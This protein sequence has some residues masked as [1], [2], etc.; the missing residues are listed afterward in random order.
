MNA[1]AHPADGFGRR[2]TG[3][4][5]KVL[6]QTELRQWEHRCI[7]EEPPPCMAA[8]PLHVDA[9][10]MAGHLQAGQWAE[11]L[12]VLHKTM[13]LPG[14]LGRICD[15]PCRLAC[16]RKDVG[17]AIQIVALERACVQHIEDRR[18]T[19]PLTAKGL[20]V[21]VI[22]GGLS[23]LTA[24]WDLARKGYGVTVF[25]DEDTVGRGLFNQYRQRLSREVLDREIALLTSLKVRFE[26]K[27][28]FAS[29]A[30]SRKCREAHDAV[31]VGLDAAEPAPWGIDS[32][33]GPDPAG[34]FGTTVQD[35]L[36]AGG[37][38]AS[39]IWQAAQGRW[40][41]TTTDRW[42]Q[43]VSLT[44]G[45]EK[46]GPQATRLFTNF[47]GIPPK[48]AV[49]MADPSAGYSQTE[50][51]AEAERCLQCQCL[52]CV[53]VCAYLEQF[54]SYPRR[55]A[56]E[57]YNNESLVLGERKANRLINSCSLCGLCE[58]VC[59]NDFAMQDLCLAARQSMVA[60][61]KMPPSAHAFALQDMAFSQSERFRLAR[62]EPGHSS[63]RRLFFPGCQLCA[64][65]PRQVAQIYRHLREALTDGVA[66]MLGCCGAPAHWAGR[67][68]SLAAE[69]ARW[70][71][72]WT[73]LGRPQPIMACATCLRIFK[74]HV[75]ETDA[76]SLWE[77][78]DAGDLPEGFFSHLEEPLAVHDPC[79]T[80]GEE[81]VQDA[82]RR[83]LSRM[84][85]PHEELHLGRGY[86]ECC[87]FGG[88]M[89]NANPALAR[90][91]AENRGRRSARDYLAYCA[92][93]RDSLAA[94][95]KRTLHLLDLFFPDPDQPDP[96]ARPRPG[97][98]RRRENRLRLKADLSR[99]LWN[100][101]PAADIAVPPALQMDPEVEALL[102]SRRILE[103]DIQKVIRHI[104][105]GGQAFRHPDTGHWL[106]CFR[107]YQAT[108]WVEFSALDEGYRIHNAY[109]HRMEVLGP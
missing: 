52:E 17:E 3:R 57:I 68:E 60:R 1:Q 49:A 84:G 23:S 25:T 97:W 73:E 39:A 15:A 41:A 63:S 33:S 29:A 76:V 92:M 71:A 90:P 106:A 16:N 75:P 89:Q 56:R 13:P 70:K 37:N 35:G 42:L 80:R 102:E 38:H 61:D 58:A 10:A 26:T 22:G 74:D 88:L 100:E 24:A 93:C 30:D 32:H 36:F 72:D 99:D 94:V 6:D 78:L 59:P 12:K 109:A 81:A 46:E 9:R 27:A 54:G 98:S 43:K 14:I 101:T 4:E 69:L 85:V 21:A 20:T 18:R 104:Q 64:S 77:V 50:A 51:L 82:V 2:P 40:A 87:G 66:L 108:F 28:V 103:E 67:Q 91:V 34:A 8:C 44:A 105:N 47:E 48:A 65:A 96:A 107:P 95:G 31:Y 11:A 83:L 55:Y 19:M 62:H 79:T 45:R 53:K 7:Q 86:T 5:K